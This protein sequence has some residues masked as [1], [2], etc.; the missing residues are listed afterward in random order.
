MGNHVRPR[1]GIGRRPVFRA[2][3][4]PGAISQSLSRNHDAD[5]FFRGDLR[6]NWVQ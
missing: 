1:N 6:G 3:A 2:A 4:L 5:N